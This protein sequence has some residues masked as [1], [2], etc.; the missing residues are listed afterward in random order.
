[1]AI[2]IFCIFSE[3][4]SKLIFIGS[5]QS[6]FLVRGVEKYWL[7][8]EESEKCVKNNHEGRI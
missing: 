7:L 8:I 4:V 2:F 5:F 6:Y 1:M 3:N